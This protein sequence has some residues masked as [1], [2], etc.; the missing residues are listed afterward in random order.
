MELLLHP[1]TRTALEALRR[2]PG[3]SYLFHGPRAVGKA[4]AAL[5]LTR[6]LIC[7]HQP[8]NPATACPS[9]RQ[10]AAG[11]YPDLEILKPEAK[12]SITIEQ[13]RTLLEH[14]S[15]RPYYQGKMRV[16][17]VDDADKLTLEAGN[18]L[19]KIIEEPPER[20]I[21]ILIA[22]QPE[23]LLATIRSRCT[24]I[25]FNTPAP[26]D[27]TALLTKRFNLT[28]S[29]AADLTTA[30][31]MPGLA[32][33][34]ASDAAATTAHQELTQAAASSLQPG[35]FHRLLLAARLAA[36]ADLTK[37]ARLLHARVVRELLAG[38][39]AALAG[40]RLAALELFRRRQ[41]AGLAPRVALEC[42]MLEL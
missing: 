24:A 4:T 27:T 3:G 20:T 38:A 33:A 37:F 34:V 36:G 6:Q 2:R 28:P 13:V 23:A 1:R 21:F 42:L 19:L 9:C 16:T 17:I 31:V 12:P 8:D 41:A 40:R 11:T 32:I 25:Y 14:L 22:E 15:R 5:E 10:L 26:A 39:D 30:T 35:L 18:A 7:D 29:G